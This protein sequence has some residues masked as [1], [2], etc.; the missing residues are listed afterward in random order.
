M[1]MLPYSRIKRPEN[2]QGKQNRN[3][4]FILRLNVKENH[5]LFIFYSVKGN[6]LE[7]EAFIV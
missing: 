7:L 4:K 5:S 3:S 2:S 1:G 6:T